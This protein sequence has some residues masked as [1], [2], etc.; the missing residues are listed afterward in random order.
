MSMRSAT[1]ISVAPLN[2]IVALFSV[3]IDRTLYLPGPKLNE[4]LF[5]TRMSP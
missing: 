1:L 3:L 4:P 2:R 5:F